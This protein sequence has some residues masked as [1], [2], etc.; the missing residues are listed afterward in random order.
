VGGGVLASKAITYS[1]LKRGVKRKRRNLSFVFHRRICGLASWRTAG[2]GDKKCL[3]R[4]R[5]LGRQKWGGLR[6]LQGKEKRGK[7]KDY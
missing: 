3:R 7:I 1:L 4:R 2:K 5:K 6:A